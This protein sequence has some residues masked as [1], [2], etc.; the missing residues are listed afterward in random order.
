MLSLYRGKSLDSGI[1]IPCFSDAALQDVPLG[2]GD[3]SGKLICHAAHVWLSCSFFPGAVDH[4][5]CLNVE[6][7]VI[8]ELVS[9]KTAVVPKEFVV[10]IRV[11]DREGADFGLPI[12][13]FDFADD[14]TV[15]ILKRIFC[16]AEFHSEPPALLVAVAPLIGPFFAHDLGVLPANVEETPQN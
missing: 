11:G 6:L 3:I 7:R 10:L 8:D 14:P 13:D 15:V 2:L 9:K 16:A 12:L 1:Y 4:P 5:R